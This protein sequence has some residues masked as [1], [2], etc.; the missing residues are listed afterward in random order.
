M[1][2]AWNDIPPNDCESHMKRN[3]VYQLQTLN[4]I[5]KEMKG[6]GCFL[7]RSSGVK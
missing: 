2:N 4:Q 3:S 1:K 5:M 6:V 7:F